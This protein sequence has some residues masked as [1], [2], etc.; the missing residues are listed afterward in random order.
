MRH[1]VGE[2]LIQAG[3]VGDHGGGQVAEIPF[4]EEGQGESP[5]RL[6]QAHPAVGALLVGGDVKGGVLEPVEDEQQ[7][8]HR[9]GKAHI[10]PEPVHG[11]AAALQAA[12]K[13]LDR[14]QD[15]PHGEHEGQIAHKAP[16]HGLHQVSGPLLT[17]SE[18]V[19]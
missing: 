2:H 14:E 9:Q 3:A 1:I 11:T 16:N 7:E 13:M 17:E 8:E 4:A 12:Q 10:E 18:D 6:R 5:Q 19:L 15:R